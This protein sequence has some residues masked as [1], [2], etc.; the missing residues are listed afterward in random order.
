MTETDKYYQSFMQ[1]VISSQL[2]SEEGDTQEQAFTRKV[3]YLLSENG[4]VADAFVAYDEKGLGT[5]KQHKTL[6]L[7]TKAA[8]QS[9]CLSLFLSIPIPYKLSPKPK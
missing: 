4:N 9:T 3:L 8:K 2:S 7:L 6:V 1:D 5:K